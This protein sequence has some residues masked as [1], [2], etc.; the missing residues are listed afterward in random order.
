MQRFSLTD[1]EVLSAAADE[2]NLTRAARRMHLV[3]SSASAHIKNLESALGVE[4]LARR[5]RGV[6]LTE[7]GRIVNRYAKQIARS[8]EQMKLELVPFAKHEAGVIRVVANYGA[9]FDYLPANIAQFLVANPEVNV[10]L[11]QMGSDQ[12]VQFVAE[13]RADIGIGAFRGTF[14]GIEFLPYR[15]DELV[16]IVPEDHPLAAFE[17]IPFEKSLAYEFVCLD[18]SSAMQRFIFEKARMLGHKIVPRI[19]VGDQSLLVG[20]VAQGAGIAVISGAATRAFELRKT[21]IVKLTDAWAQRRLRIALSTRRKQQSRW[22]APLIE[23][24]TK[25]APK[26]NA[27][28]SAP[29]ISGAPFA[30]ASLSALRTLKTGADQ[31]G[32]PHE[33]A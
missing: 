24:L 1:L 5:V 21:R 29:G 20:L 31:M 15:N 3:T 26:D 17:S 18:N 25:D 14:P 10:E 7:A 13:N 22:L 28:E 23:I 16:L 8:F 30:A 12:V 19:H 33:G 9:S 27:G 6:E 4:L 11:V 2:E 32:K